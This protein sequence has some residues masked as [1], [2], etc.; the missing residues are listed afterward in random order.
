MREV[1]AQNVVVL[2]IKPFSS[3]IMHPLINRVGYVCIHVQ[4]AF[5]KLT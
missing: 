2:C 1:F 3:R 5:Q 4:K